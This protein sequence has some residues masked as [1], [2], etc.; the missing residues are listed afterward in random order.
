LGIGFTVIAQEASTVAG[1]RQWKRA[2]MAKSILGLQP[3]MNQEILALPDDRAVMICV[4]RGPFP[5]PHPPGVPDADTA[6]YVM[7]D[8]GHPIMLAAGPGSSMATIGLTP[9]ETARLP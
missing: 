6:I 5:T 8:G 9:S 1:I 4:Y 3:L 7:P 2:Q